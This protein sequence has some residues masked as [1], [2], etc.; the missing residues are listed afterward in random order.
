MNRSSAG[1][2]G[3]QIATGEVMTSLARTDD[4]LAVIGIIILIGISISSYG[5]FWQGVLAREQYDQI[6]PP[7]STKANVKKGKRQML[8][9]LA[10]ISIII[11]GAVFYGIMTSKKLKA[12]KG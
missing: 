10:V 3:G 9:A 2:I 12:A 8:L 7:G 6:S 1:V 11:I 5:T 4:I